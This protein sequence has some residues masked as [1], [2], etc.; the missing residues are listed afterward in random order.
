LNVFDRHLLVTEPP[1]GKDFKGRDEA[2]AMT[3]PSV[4]SMQIFI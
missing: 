1:L 4:H 3:K 2:C